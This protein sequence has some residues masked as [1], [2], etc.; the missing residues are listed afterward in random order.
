MIRQAAGEQEDKGD[1]VK[2]LL[3]LG[4]GNICQML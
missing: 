3:D 2:L 4:E 1:F